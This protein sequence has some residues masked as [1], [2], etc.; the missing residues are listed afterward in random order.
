MKKLSGDLVKDLALNKRE[1]ISL[2]GAGGKTTIMY[3]L[4]KEL[5]DLQYRVITTTTTKIFPPEPDQSRALILGGR[6]IFPEIRT[7]L[8]RYGRVT[9]AAG[10]VEKNKLAGV[11]LEDVSICWASGLAD[12]LIVEADGSARRPIKAPNDREPVV[13]KETTL[14]LTVMGLSAL[15]RP[16]NQD[17]AFR[18]EIISRL[19][20]LSL[21]APMTVEPL[22]RLLVHPEGGMKG[23]RPSMRAFILLTQVDLEPEPGVGQRLAERI[24][25][26]GRDRVGRVLIL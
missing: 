26:L 1:L 21:E 15:N 23:F 16:L 11:D 12:Y 9:W 6:A 7:A 25:E 3:S 14:F 22:A 10:R 13:P 18:P 17:N 20:G 2:V 19:T 5:S 8:N 24:E 4:S